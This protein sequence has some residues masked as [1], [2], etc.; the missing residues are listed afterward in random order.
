M[1]HN[2]V[3]GYSGLHF[4]NS[5]SRVARGLDITAPPFIDRALLTARRPP[6][7]QFKH[8]EY[9]PSGT[10]SGRAETLVSMFKLTQGQ[11]KELKCKCTEDENK[12]THTLYEALSAHI[13]RC[14]CRARFLPEVHETRLYIAVDGRTRLRPP[15][16][17]WYF[18]NVI[19]TATLVC[20]CGDLE[21]GSTRSV[22]GEIHKALT[23]MDDEYLRS[24]L[25]FLEVTKDLK[26]LVRGAH[27]YGN[28]NLGITSWAK[29][30]VYEAD[31][32]W[33][34]PFFMGPAAIPFEGL[35]YILGSP[36]ND[37]GVA[38]VIRLET[39][40]MELFRKLFYDI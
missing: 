23:R 10:T 28:P 33:G 9:E 5:W 11:L 6:R 39:E 15:L 35:C 16:P 18:G 13:W 19:F 31:F 29:L 21:S 25:D 24:A 8:I 36:V 22:A 37:G 7:P 27:T 30:P 26:A 2:V 12:G 1:H 20:L 3:D 38:V 14:V 17:Q 32:G 34:K 4:I 40:H